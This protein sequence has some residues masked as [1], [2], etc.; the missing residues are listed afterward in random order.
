MNSIDN[1]SHQNWFFIVSIASV[2]II[3][4][5]WFDSVLERSLDIQLK[6][7]LGSALNH[8][9]SC[10]SSLRKLNRGKFDVV[11]QEFMAKTDKMD[12]M[13]VGVILYRL[14]PIAIVQPDFIVS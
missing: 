11:A 6:A 8:R 4:F 5:V 2:D 3:N 1:C 14:K 10:I 9:H 13:P 7:V 12:S